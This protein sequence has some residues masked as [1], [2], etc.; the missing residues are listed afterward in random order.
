MNNL[1]EEIYIIKKNQTKFLEMK[2]MKQEIKNFI[3]NVK[4]R[5]DFTKDQI[6]HVEDRTSDLEKFTKRTDK[7]TP[8]NENN[9]QVILDTI[10][11]LNICIISIP[12]G[13]EINKGTDNVFHVILEENFP[14][15]ER[16]SNIHT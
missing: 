10:K 8:K 3:E 11:H 12:E 14:N 16:H 9:I 15:L 4:S 2:A 13:E 6:S 5:L 1:K 7:I